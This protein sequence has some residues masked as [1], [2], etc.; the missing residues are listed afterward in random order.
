V[1]RIC[2]SL[3]R[4][5][6]KYNRHQPAESDVRP[7]KATAAGHHAGLAFIASAQFLGVC[8]VL[9]TAVA[10]EY[11]DVTDRFFD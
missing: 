5:R 6:R 9:V 10:I 8:S 4:K 1:K 11:S 7:R 2:R 3:L